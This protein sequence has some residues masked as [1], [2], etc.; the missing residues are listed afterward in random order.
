ME[1]K[2]CSK[3]KVEKQINEFGKTSK[4][5]K[6]GEKIII[7]K[8]NCKLC[9]SKYQKER[10]TQ[11]KEENIELYRKK[12]AEYYA[13]DKER[14]KQYFSIHE[15]KEK[16]R[17]YFRSYKKERRSKDLKYLLME[18]HRRRIN[19]AV[20]NKYNSSKELLGCEIDF[21]IKWIEFTMKCDMTWE[22][23]GTYW[24]IDHIIP[25]KNYDIENPEEAKKAFNWKNTWALEAKIN[26]SKN[27][28][29]IPDLINEHQ[30]LLNEFVKININN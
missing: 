9:E 21:Y 23:Y 5:N 28:N 30:K 11:K 18:N 17:A 16:R 1:T 27:A 12:C 10:R 6:S 2:I 19:N 14:R 13:N 24:H 26:S 29:V 8:Y 22:N 4:K 25:I 3:C 20:Q 7:I 15:N